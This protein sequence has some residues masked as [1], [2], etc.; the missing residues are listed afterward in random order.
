MFN[1]QLSMSHS[2]VLI[3]YQVLNYKWYIILDNYN[4]I[5]GN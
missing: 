2:Y 5:M 3:V 1:N 4:Y